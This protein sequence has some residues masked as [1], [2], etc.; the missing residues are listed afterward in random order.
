M[1][2][3][4]VIGSRDEKVMTGPVFTRGPQQRTRNFAKIDC[5]WISFAGIRPKDANEN[6]GFGVCGGALTERASELRRE[7]H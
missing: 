7:R 4:F 2:Y 1:R 6:I 3:A 5:W